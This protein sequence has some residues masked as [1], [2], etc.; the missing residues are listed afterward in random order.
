MFVRFIKSRWDVS[1]IIKNKRKK[2]KK[3]KNKVTGILGI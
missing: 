1:K 3:V 2:K